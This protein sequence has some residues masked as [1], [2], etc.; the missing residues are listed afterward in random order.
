MSGPIPYMSHGFLVFREVTHHIDDI[1]QL[2]V[3]DPIPL[4]SP[5]KHRGAWICIA[6]DNMI[7]GIFSD[8]AAITQLDLIKGPIIINVASI[9][10]TTIA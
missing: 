1:N 10:T 6:S 8:S 4:E 9:N 5:T 3:H 2:V 7:Q